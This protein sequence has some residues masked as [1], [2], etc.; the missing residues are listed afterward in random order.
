MT[1]ASENP[2]G[3]N[4]AWS[5]GYYVYST[6]AIADRHSVL[7][8]A[9]KTHSFDLKMASSRSAGYHVGTGSGDVLTFN[10]TFAKDTWYH[11]MWTQSKSEGLT[12]YVNGNKVD[13]NTWTKTGLT[14]APLDIVGGTGFEGYIDE[15]KVYN[16]VLTADEV[17][18]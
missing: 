14:H 8:D 1:F 13:T 2:F 7:M 18:V 9:D 3:A 6:V 12:M 15:L 16:R 5:I 17:K 11:V 10:Y 4:D